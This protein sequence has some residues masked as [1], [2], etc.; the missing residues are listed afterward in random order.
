MSE[1]ELKRDLDGTGYAIKPYEYQHGPRHAGKAKVYISLI[2]S[3]LILDEDQVRDLIERLQ[4]IC[5]DPPAEVD[6]SKEN[7]R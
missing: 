6:T 1:P 5:P 7:Q 3:D 2:G 4:A